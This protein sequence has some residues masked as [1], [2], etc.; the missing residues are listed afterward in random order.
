MILDDLDISPEASSGIDGRHHTEVGS[1]VENIQLRKQIAS[2][3]SIIDN[4]PEAVIV[5]DP[6]GRLLRK[7]QAAETILGNFSFDFAPE[8][9]P[10][11]LGLYLDDAK[12]YFPGDRMPLVRALKGEDVDGEEI[13]QISPGGSVP[14]WLSMSAHPLFNKLK[15][16]SGAVI[17]IRDITYRKQIGLSRESHARRMEALYNFSRAIA[18]AG[19]DLST[20]TDVI[21]VKSSGYFNDASIVALLGSKESH[22][23]IAS[24]HH[25]EPD[26][27]AKLRKHMM[28]IDKDFNSGLLGGVI[29][30]G[31]PILIPSINPEQLDA[32][33]LPDF[34]E[35][36]HQTEV[37]GMLVVPITGKSGPLGTIVIFRHSETKPYTTE[38][39]NFL[40]DLANRAGLAIEN[41]QLLDSLTEQIKARISTKEALDVSEERFRAIFDSTT[42][43]IKVLDR[44]GTI[45][46][47]N[48]AFQS[49]MGYTEAEL[50]GKSFYSLLHRDDALRVFRLFNDLVMSDVLDFRLEH[51][52]IHKD[53]SVNWVKTIFSSVKKGGGDESLAI[54]VGIVENITEQKRIE[55]EVAELKKRLHGSIEMERLRLAQELHDGPMQDLYSAVYQIEAIRSRGDARER[56]ALELIRQDIQKVLEELRATAKELRPPTLANFGLEKAIRSYIQD[57][58][59][60]FPG[61][62]I[63]SSLA[64]DRQILPE[65]VSLALFRT[66]QQS[67]SNVARHADADS[68]EV[69]FSLDAEAAVLEIIDN[70]KG[71][72]L[73]KNWVGFVRK[74]HFGLAG[75]AERIEALGGT[76]SVESQPGEGTSIRVMIPLIETSSEPGRN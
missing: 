43:G 31:E 27:R 51:R 42:L 17:L 47:V 38:D 70:G 57:F 46:Q 45:L 36:I 4:I 22:L 10:E 40:T 15:Q 58:Q 1:E 28:L 60:K 49:L 12:T 41:S 71:F 44:E 18:E 56:D 29:Q 20:I 19:N 55:A 25:P 14:V 23:K 64:Q 21:A 6:F 75:M 73:P 8:N 7:N 74:G 50:I 33:M 24:Y 54:V 2:L 16:I 69:V 61:I 53:G 35:Y 5:T 48:P 39:Q 59:D 67:L 9:W 68:A 37:L 26:S 65:D 32:I 76:F 62:R 30:T 52:T 11:K 3:E 13:I 34:A 66:L 63:H 72:D